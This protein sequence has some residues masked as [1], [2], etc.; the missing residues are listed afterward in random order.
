M[1]ADL[2]CTLR[3]VGTAHIVSRAISP[4]WGGATACDAC[5]A[6][7]SC[8]AAHPAA[9]LQI[10]FHPS[11]RPSL[12]RST[13][14]L[15]LF[16]APVPATGPEP[17]CWESVR[18]SPHSKHADKLHKPSGRLIDASRSRCCSL[19]TAP[20]HGVDAGCAERPT[21]GWAPSVLQGGH[22]EL[23]TQ[24]CVAHLIQRCAG[25]AAEE[26]LRHLARIAHGGGPEARCVRVP[27]ELRPRL[28]CS[29]LCLTAAC[30][31]RCGNGLEADMPVHR[32]GAC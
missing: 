17:E 9:T 3:H 30:C 20:M 18:K 26:Q 24:R 23:Q 7:L 6:A 28:P 19:G 10:E 8:T 1:V 22:R 5:G 21:Q 13:I 15:Y 29:D 27:P 25:V 12:D 14:V 16:S 2:C 4:L 11:A 32:E 31:L